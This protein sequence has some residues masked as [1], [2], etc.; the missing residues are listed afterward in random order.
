MSLVSR[1]TS[2]PGASRVE[3]GEVGGDRVGEGRASG[4]RWSMPHDDAVG[5]HRLQVEEQLRTSGRADDGRQHPGQR[6][7]RL[8]RLH[9]RVERQL[10]D[11]RIAAGGG[12]QTA[13]SA[14][15]RPGQLAPARPHPVGEEAGEQPARRAV[16]GQRAAALPSRSVG[17]LLRAVGQRA[18]PGSW[19]RAEHSAAA[20]LSDCRFAAPVSGS[21]RR[22]MWTMK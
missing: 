13:R 14:P 22:C 8:A 12:R 4:C 7:P 9:Q 20:W 15:A 1:E 19:R 16:G 11:H 21:S 3:P 6:S 18:S 2:W 5:G 17:G 10:D